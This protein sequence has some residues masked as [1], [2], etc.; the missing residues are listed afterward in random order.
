MNSP[1]VTCVTPSFRYSV[2]SVMFVIWKLVTKPVSAALGVIT[3][4]EVVCVLSVVVALVTEGWC[5]IRLTAMVAVAVV[6][7]SPAVVA[8][9]DS[10]TVK[11]PEVSE[12]V[13]GVNFNPAAP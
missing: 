11:L 1:L 8:L 12:F 3:R 4:P 2:P 13:V 7:P 6:P 5:R 9:V 10:W